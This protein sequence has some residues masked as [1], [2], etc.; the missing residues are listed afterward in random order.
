MIS[1]DLSASVKLAVFDRYVHKHQ[2]KLW[3][4][5][6]V[7]KVPYKFKSF[8]QKCNK[9]QKNMKMDE[10][11]KREKVRVYKKRLWQRNNQKKTLVFV[12]HINV[13]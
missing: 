4:F 8:G 12:D 1:L 6:I 11:S 2:T 5:Q 10:W 7:L 9:I 13:K 3:T